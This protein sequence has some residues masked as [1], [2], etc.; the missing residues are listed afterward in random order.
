VTYGKTYW[1][2]EDFSGQVHW[3][4]ISNQRA[5]WALILDAARRTLYTGSN[6]S[7]SHIS[8]DE[9]LGGGQTWVDDDSGFGDRAASTMVFDGTDPRRLHFPGLD[10]T[11]STV[12]WDEDLSPRLEYYRPMELG[13]CYGATYTDYASRFRLDSYGINIYTSRNV[14]SGQNV[15]YVAAS[16]FG[17]MYD[18]AIHRGEYDDAQ[19]DY[20]WAL[21]TGDHGA[22]GGACSQLPTYVNSD[23]C[24]NLCDASESA[25]ALPMALMAHLIVD[26]RDDRVVYAV[27]KQSSAANYQLY[28]SEDRGGHWATWGADVFVYGAPGGPSLAAWGLYKII[29]DPQVPEVLYLSF[30]SNAGIFKLDLRKGYVENISNLD[31]TADDNPAARTL[32]TYLGQ[33][34]T[35]GSTTFNSAPTIY[36]VEA[37]AD[38][39]TGL[40]RLRIAVAPFCDSGWGLFPET[41]CGVTNGGGIYTRLVDNNDATAD[42]ARLW[43]KLN[44][45]SPE[46]RYFQAY[47]V[48]FSPLDAQT[49]CMVGVNIFGW[50][51]AGNPPD[52]PAGVACTRDGGTTWFRPL[53]APVNCKG[54]AASPVTPSLFALGLEGGGLWLM[55]LDAPPAP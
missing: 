2:E 15:L 32:G 39:D 49:G 47:R 18:G 25:E 19:G 41:T 38:V 53:G 1:T 22:G 33:T 36:D 51:S 55:D 21:A 50:S 35:L 13:F 30:Y 20:L 46:V 52:I 5:S 31:I 6:V 26:P 27:I 17:N 7:P 44:Y 23:T 34:Y 10:P 3:H 40:T 37:T 48:A 8:F 4:N 14:E 16:H 43:D 11:Y 28:R 54:V 12:A 29:A 9:V 24:Y 42:A 45:D